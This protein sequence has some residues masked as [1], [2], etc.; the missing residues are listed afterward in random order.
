MTDGRFRVR[1]GVVDVVDQ[2]RRLPPRFEWTSLSDD[3]KFRALYEAII[4][5]E[6]QCQQSYGTLYDR[7]KELEQAMA[8]IQEGE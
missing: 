7:I 8:R 1:D 2:M 3:N 6:E 4:L 5:L